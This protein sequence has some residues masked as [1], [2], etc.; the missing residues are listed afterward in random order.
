MI[1]FQKNGFLA[2]DISEFESGFKKEYAQWLNFLYDINQYGQGLQYD[3]DINNENGQQLVCASLFARCVSMYQSTIILSVKGMEIQA[4]ILLRCLLESIFSL[5]AS[6]KSEEMVKKYV[7]ADFIERRKFFN[8]VRMCRSESMKDLA[9]KH[10]TD[11]VIEEIKEDIKKTEAQR[12]STEQIAIKADLHEW[13]LTAYS[14]FSHSVHSSARDIEKHL[15]VDENEKIMGLQ[16]EPT[17]DNYD[18]LFATAAEC[19]LQ[20]FM[21]IEKVFENNTSEFVKGKYHKLEEMLK[22][23]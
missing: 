9:E 8:K 10:A 15:I 20:A 18:L 5:V 19:M 6:S 12:L 7:N 3:L 2:K 11:E 16:N 22:T 14:I 4:T 1:D 23:I 21:A 13:Y 17:I